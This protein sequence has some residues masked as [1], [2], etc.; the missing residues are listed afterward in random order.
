MSTYTMRD[1]VKTYEAYCGEAIASCRFTREIVGGQ[2]A[3]PEGIQA[4]CLHHLHI[5]EG[6]ELDAAVKRILGEEIGEREVTT[7]TGELKE[8]ESYGLNVLRHDDFGPWIGDWQLKAALKQ[9]ASRVGLFVSK[10]GSKGD[11]AEM[12]KISAHGI[13]LHGPD[14]RIHLMDESGEAPAATIYQKFLGRVNTPT[15][16]KSIV[17]DAE[18][19]PAGTRFE[20]RF[21]WYDGKL[22][23]KDIVAIFAA[24]PVIGVGSVK[25][26]ERG[27]FDIERLEVKEKKAKAA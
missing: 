6:P 13:S 10:R 17:N 7:E 26:L 25:S 22:T 20:F 1:L 2:P 18:C 9:G 16:A 15:G 8:K 12:G 21:Q 24:L 3:T 27:K 23:E 4:F 19:A 14:F 11:M 5:P